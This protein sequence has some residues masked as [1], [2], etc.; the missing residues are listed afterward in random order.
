MMKHFILFLLEYTFT[1]N[2][3][4]IKLVSLNMNGAR[5]DT[6]RAFIF[7]LIRNNNLNVMFL[8]RTCI[9]ND[10]ESDWKRKWIGEDIYLFIFSR[11][12]S[13]SGG[14]VFSFLKIFFFFFLT[15]LTLCS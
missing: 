2:V 1:L 3:C 14:L 12:S 13:N 11:K 5:V 4:D 15:N 10:N 6:K 9:T 7:N 8:Q